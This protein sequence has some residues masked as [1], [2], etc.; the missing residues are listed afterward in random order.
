MKKFKERWQ[1]HHNWQLI[2][3]LLGI[4]VL[5]Y[6]S[7]KLSLLFAKDSHIVYNILIGIVIYFL[8]LKLVL[9]LFKKLETKW[10]VTYR[11]EIISIFLA[12][13][14]TGST[15]VFVGR[16]LIKLIGITKENL[17]IVVFWVL[18]III[19]LILY[20]ILLVLFGWIFGQFTFFWNFEKKMLIRMGFKRFLD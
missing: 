8:L 16:P 1:I 9:F 10:K 15:S 17:N 11:W 7:F 5:G 4:L 6:S 12:F 18:Y 2:F 20:Q 3:P 13:A 19:G 14:T